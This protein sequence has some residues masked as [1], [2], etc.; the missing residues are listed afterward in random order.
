MHVTA[1]RRPAR[2]ARQEL[3]VR[4]GV[5][6]LLLGAVVLFFVVAP[7][8]RW[9]W[10]RIWGYRGVLLEGLWTTAWMAT[11]ALVLGLVLGLLGGVLRLSS[12]PALNQVGV[13][14]VEIVRGTPLLVQMLVA[15]FCIAPAVGG[16]LEAMGAPMG[17]LS[18]VTDRRAVGV[19]ALGVFAGAYVTE[20][21]RAAI[22]SVDRGQTEAAISQGMSRAQVMRHV[23]LP[24]ALRR[25]VPPLAGELV[26][27]VKDSS[28]LYVIAVS[29]V[30]KRAYEVYA[31]TNK[32]FEPFLALAVLY[33]ALTF[34]LSRL[35]RWL[36][37]RLT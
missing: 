15:Y 10:H 9:E 12:R 27:L 22:Q 21:V 25:M 18:F 29:E 24:Q 3:L 5:T 33:L 28:L 32:T 2:D 31:A 6:G 19:A 26:N 13:L 37:L 35:A 36:E 7:R 17:V 16:A 34:P 4:A 20:I 30:S 14:Y 11:A 1:W 23:L 8:Y